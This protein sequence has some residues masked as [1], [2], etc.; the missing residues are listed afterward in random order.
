MELEEAGRRARRRGALHVAITAL[1]RAAELSDPA[2]RATAP[3]VGRRARCRAR[4]A[5]ARRAAAARGRSAKPR[6]ARSRGLDRGD[7]QPAPPRST[8]SA[9]PGWS[10]RPSGRE[11]PAIATCTSGCCGWR[12]PGRGGQIRSGRA[13]HPRRRRSSARR[14]RGSGPAGARH[15]RVRRSDRPRRRVPASA[16]GCRGHADAR[17]GVGTAP[18]AGGARSR[19]LRHRRGAPRVRRRRRAHGGTPR[20]PAPNAR[21]PRDRRRVSRR[22]GGRGARRRGGTAARDRARRAT[23]D[24]GRRDRALRGRRHARRRRYRRARRGPRRAAGPGRRRQGH[25]RPG[26]GRPRAQRT[27]RVAGTTTPTR[28]PGGCSTRPIRPTT[29]SWLAG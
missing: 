7:D 22:V 25:R 6:G 2:Q 8:Q 4:S 27:G 17:Y 10:T 15:L 12:S 13:Q 20:P 1:R 23:V 16:A 24:R 5:R 14:P 26:S 21:S 19:R 9:S 3:A 28:P 11:T 18:G 29:Q